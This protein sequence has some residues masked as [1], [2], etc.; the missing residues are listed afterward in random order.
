MDCLYVS[1]TGMTEPLGR[2]QVLGYVLGLARRGFS[3]EI[4]SHEPAGTSAED[5]A[6]T[7]ELIE[8]AGVRWLPQVRSASHRLTTKIWESTRAV[9]VGLAEAL[10][11][12]PGIVHAR[13][14]LPAAVADVVA[15]VAPGAK[16]LFDCRGMLGDEYVDGG[17]W[18]KDRLEYRLLKRYERRAFS[19]AEGIVVLTEALRRWM[20]AE[21]VVP[22]ATPIAVVP[23]CVETERFGADRAARARARAELGLGE[24]PVLVYSG[25][26]GS[27]YQEREMA[28]LAGRLRAR[29]PDLVWLVFTRGDATSLRDAARSAGVTNVVVRGASPADM[30]RLLPAGDIGVS[31][32]RPCFSKMGSSPTKVAEYLAA[33]MT[34]VVNAGIGDQGDLASDADACVVATSYDDGELDR[35]ADRALELALRQHDERVAAS[36]RVV[37]ERFS[38]TEL[39]IPRYEAMY[40]HLLGTT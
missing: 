6:R 17:H 27:W 36:R 23:C 12:R 19:R 37:R 26:L 5:L 40:R 24:G 34:A 8:A 22:D 10:R 30:P 7:R 35:V 18:T 38:L 28:R 32:I 1:H 39:G 29:R 33:G 20:R 25:S 31:F 16:M 13:S 11:R 9:L 2:S 21:R 14:Y 15:S 4:L 3:M